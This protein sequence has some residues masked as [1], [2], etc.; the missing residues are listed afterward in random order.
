M[1][2]S[3][4]SSGGRAPLQLQRGAA[5]KSVNDYTERA[6]SVMASPMMNSPVMARKCLGIS[7]S[8]C[9]E[10]VAGRVNL[11]GSAG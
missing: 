10:L 7:I 9:G 5:K 11:M 4:Q 2:I 3:T 8:W 6:R 1:L